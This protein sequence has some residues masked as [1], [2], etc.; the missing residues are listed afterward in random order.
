MSFLVMMNDSKYINTCTPS[1][2][3]NNVQNDILDIWYRATN[4]T[5]QIAFSFMVIIINPTIEITSHFG[6]ILQFITNKTLK[7]SLNL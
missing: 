3:D 2:S 4:H 7:K 6:E 5:I 1:L